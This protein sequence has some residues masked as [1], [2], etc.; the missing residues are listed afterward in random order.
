MCIRDRSMI[1]QRRSVDT[2]T[3]PRWKYPLLGLEL[4]KVILLDGAYCDCKGQCVSLWRSYCSNIWCWTTSLWTHRQCR[5]QQRVQVARNISKF[6]W[7]QNSTSQIKKCNLNRIKKIGNAWRVR[8]YSTSQW[9][10]Y[11]KLSLPHRL[12]YLFRRKMKQKFT[13]F[14]VSGSTKTK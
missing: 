5:A 2:C 10:F 4:E 8:L 11:K 12:K 13:K 7:R 9:R 6:S 14:T 3:S 1:A